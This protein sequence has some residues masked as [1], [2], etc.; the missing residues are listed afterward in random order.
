[1]TVYDAGQ[2]LHNHS[3]VGSAIAELIGKH[4]LNQLIP[5]VSKVAVTIQINGVDVDADGFFNHLEK[6]LE[7]Y[8]IQEAKRLITER[9]ESTH[10]ALYDLERIVSEKVHDAFPE[11]RWEE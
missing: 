4:D 1:M 10:R 11:V 8:A 3:F 7:S 2:E 5:D 6:S 9:L